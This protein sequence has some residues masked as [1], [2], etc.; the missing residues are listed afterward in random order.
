[1]HY[2]LSLVLLL[3]S[4]AA[5]LRAQQAEAGR[6]GFFEAPFVHPALLEH[7][8][9][10]ISDRHPNIMAFDLEEAQT[11]NQIAGALDFEVIPDN[12]D[13]GAPWVELKRTEPEGEITTFRY[14][15][16]RQDPDGTI[17]LKCYSWGG[18]SGTWS[19]HL[20][21]QIV[22][23]TQI[24]YDDQNQPYKHPYRRL[25]LVSQLPTDFFE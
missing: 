18:G 15:A 11:S 5:Q 21:V 3:G 16:M 14:R 17:Y 24:R 25:Q 13:G 10:W 12:T 4:G 7:F 6:L 22:P 9:G 20:A 23:A 19:H 8:A 1:M 2:F